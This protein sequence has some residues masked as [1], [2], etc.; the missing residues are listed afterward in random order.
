MLESVVPH[1]RLSVYVPEVTKTATVTIHDV[2]RGGAGVGRL[3]SGQIVFVPWTDVG[4]EVEI[5]YIASEDRSLQ[6]TPVAWKKFGPDRI[7]PKCPYFSKCGGCDWQ[8]IPYDR[9]W[10]IKVAGAQNALS[11]QSVTPPQIKEYPAKIQWSYR[12]RAQLRGRG[13]R[14]GFFSRGSNSFVGVDRCDVL[15]ERINETLP[16]IGTEATARFQGPYKVEI[17]LRNEGQVDWAFNQRHS[18]LGFQQAHPD[19][20]LHLREWVRSHLT[21]QDVLVD[22]YGGNGNLSLGIAEKFKEAHCVDVSVPDQIAGSSLIF[23]KSDVDRWLKSSDQRFANRE[24]AVILDP[25]RAGLGPTIDIFG[26]WTKNNGTTEIIHIGC[27]A[28]AAARDIARL[29]KLGFTLQD[30]GV[31]DLFPQTAHVEVLAYL[32][33]RT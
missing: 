7:E 18:S 23:H 24:S 1:E 31:A 12:N 32:V 19:Q 4:D 30:Y 20:N 21:S 28:D 22:L 16:K 15:D 3:Q 9:Q 17:A 29:I 11:R 27:D 26:P 14:L 13:E 6:G 25:P 8:H 33:R 5:T 2:S 10:K